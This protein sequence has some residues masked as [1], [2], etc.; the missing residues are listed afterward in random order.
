MP[1][2]LPHTARAS[3]VDEAA[4]EPCPAPFN[5]AAYAL[6]AARGPDAG[7]EALRV[8]GAARES[9]S[10]AEL[11]RAVGRIAAGLAAR[12]VGR[13]DRVA[14]RIGSSVAFP[15]LFLGAIAAGAVPAPTST[16][17]TAGEFAAIA[18]D[19]APRLV[20]ADEGLATPPVA[21][22]ETVTLGDWRALMA[23]APA[24]PVATMPEDPGFLVYTS[25]TGGRPKGVLHAQRAAWARRMMW[26][27]WYGLGPGDRV[28]HAGAFNWTYTLGTGLIDPWAAGATAIVAGDR[29][30]PEAWP[31]IIAAEGA[32]IFAAVPGVYRRLLRAPDGL[33]DRLGALRH[34]LTAGEKLP[35]TVR[36]SWTRATG[37]PLYEALGM[38]EVSTYCSA[39]PSVP[40]RAGT[41]GRPQRGRRVAVIDAAGRPVPVG[42]PGL[43]AVARRDP[44]LM[45]GYWRRPEETAAA[46]RGEWFVTGDRAAMDADG[47]VTH[48]GRADELM[49]ALGYRVSPQEVEEALAAHPGVA[50]IAVAE[51]PVR[52]DLRL[53]AAF[54][55]PAA[56]WPGEAALSAFAAG[57]LAAYKC[58]KLWIPVDALP[59][60]ANGKL[61]R[62]ALV[63]AHRRDRG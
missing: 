42:E 20:V 35:E 45:L 41:V 30:E 22:A 1:D 17:L 24:P 23:P 5:I 43:L 56:E 36:E 48:L 63:E 2:P 59:R 52:A 25:G 46:F 54:V 32:T 14:L 53:I 57:R 26:A 9:W 61:I 50:E 28:L 29:P 16:Q 3:L 11:D 38:S 8:L 6:A 62:R 4:P 51:L 40:P 58:P 37:R 55:V 21:G 27:G 33:R 12:G 44:G 19:L 10:Y 13:G 18:E 7:K 39:S 47:Y 31:R 49:T 15:L 34:G 60:T